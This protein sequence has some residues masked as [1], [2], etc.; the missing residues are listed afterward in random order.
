MLHIVCSGN[1]AVVGNGPLSED[2][3]ARINGS[4]YDCVVRFNDRKNLREGEPTT[5]HVVRDL[6]HAPSGIWGLFGGG[7]RDVP[8][9]VPH[10]KVF[11]QPV[12]TQPGAICS[13]FEH[14]TSLPPILVHERSTRGGT[15]APPERIFPAC[16]KC[17]SVY[18]CD[19]SAS[20]FGP[21]TGA[22]I[23]NVLNAAPAT[24]RIDVFGMNWRGGDHHLDFQQPTLVSDCCD[25]C[26]IHPTASEN[27][28][29]D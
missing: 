12:T 26:V 24:T 3:R 17:G 18:E 4:G 13:L 10:E 16:E 11:V 7:A 19:T 5:V 21:S 29:P 1:I 25:K 22:A 27:Y 28:T 15:H 8:G 20:R 9:L 14:A 6:P 2:D 23:L